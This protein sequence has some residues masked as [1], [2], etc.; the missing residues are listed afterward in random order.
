MPNLFDYRDVKNLIIWLFCALLTLATFV[1]QSDQ[2]K[3]QKQYDDLHSLIVAIST[4]QKEIRRDQVL[5]LVDVATL[6]ASTRK[7]KDE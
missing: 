6:K 2:S 1:Y 5:M 3:I 7:L 4:N